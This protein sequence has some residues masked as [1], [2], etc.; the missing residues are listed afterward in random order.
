VLAEAAGKPCIVF[1]GR[2][3][4]GTDALTLASIEPDTAQ[5]IAHAPRLLEE[6]AFA[7]ARDYG[8]G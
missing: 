3:A 4:A 5:S 8:I 7:W 2:A 1:A 6:L